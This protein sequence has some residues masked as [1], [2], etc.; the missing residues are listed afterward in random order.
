MAVEARHLNLFPIQ[1]IQ[2][3]QLVNHTNQ[4]NAVNSAY[5][6]SQPMCFI[7]LPLGGASLP[8]NRSFY[9]SPAAVACDSVVQAKTSVNTDSGLTHNIPAPRKRS[10]DSTNQ[11]YAIPNYPAPE[12]QSSVSQL[13]CFVAGEYIL[14]QVQQYQMEVDA[15]ISQHTKRIRVELLERQKQ[16]ARLMAAAIGEVAMKKLKEKDDQIQR[17]GKLNLALQERVKSLY[18]EN[19]LWRDLAKTNEAAAISLRSN[20]DQVLLHRCVGGGGGRRAVAEEEVESCCGSNSSCSDEDNQGSGCVG[21]RRCKMCGE[22][23]SC[24]LLLPCRHLCLCGVCGSGSRQLQACPVCNS[25]MNATL[26]VN[27][28]SS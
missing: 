19:Q 22:R 4:G 16:Q 20:L 21:D 12:K 10:R 6:N 25:S 24:V 2:D 8:E 18:V 14:P 5:S 11:L 13:P 9:Q 3:R 26:H 7:G 15:I 1:L 23:E 17:M 27:M 28:S